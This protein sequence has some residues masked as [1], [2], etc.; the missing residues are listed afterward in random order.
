MNPIGGYSGSDRILRGGNWFF[1]AKSCRSANRSKDVAGNRSNGIG[2]RLVRT[3]P[4]APFIPIEIGENKKLSFKDNGDGTLTDN[5]TGYLWT[6]C[7]AGASGNDCKNGTAVNKNWA[8]AKSYCQDLGLKGFAG[9]NDWRLPSI[10]ELTLIHD[11]TIGTNP[12]INKTFFENI[13]S[14]KNVWSS[15]PVK[16][17]HPS[18]KGT[19]H[20]AYPNKINHLD[21][22]DK[23]SK[24]SVLCIRGDG[25]KNDFIILTA[26]LLTMLQT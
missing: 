19:V 7:V 9:F 25:F 2:F 5:N 26:P 3:L 1:E 21:W 11:F 6:K 17:T 18:H 4:P 20:T 12:P 10:K 8:E 15:T 16:L 13:P 22:Q 24:H 14:G 23:S